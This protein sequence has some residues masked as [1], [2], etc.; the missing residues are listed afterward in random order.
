[1]INEVLTTPGRLFAGD[2]RFAKAMFRYCYLP[3]ASDDE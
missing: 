2:Y 1:M 3:Q